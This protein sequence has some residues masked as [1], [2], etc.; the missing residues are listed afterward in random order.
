MGDG[1]RAASSVQP[2]LVDGRPLRNAERDLLVS[3]SAGQRDRHGRLGKC[4]KLYYT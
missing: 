4:T 2:A 3:R 1:E